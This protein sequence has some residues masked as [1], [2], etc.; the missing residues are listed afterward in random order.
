VPEIQII[1]TRLEQQR[2]AIDKAIEELRSID[3]ETVNANRRPGKL[4]RS[5]AAASPTD[6]RQRQIEAMRRYW[7]ERKAGGKKA[8]AKK[9]ARKGGITPEGRK[10][11]SEMM[12]K[13]WAA[14]KE[15]ETATQGASPAKTKRRKRRL[16]P[17][18]RQRIVEATK[19]RWAA[20]RAADAAAEA[21]GKKAAR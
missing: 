21:K 18:G 15:A 2:D 16:T 1:I 8:A 11:L 20:K 9:A 6:G 14:K 10:R 4:T 3:N 12:R 5:R 7:A 19:R 13:R 17:E